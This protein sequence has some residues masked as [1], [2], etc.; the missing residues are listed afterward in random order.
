MAAETVVLIGIGCLRGYWRFAQ[1]VGAIMFA[2]WLALTIQ[3]KSGASISYLLFGLILVVGW[4]WSF[5]KS[6][7]ALGGHRP[8][9]HDR[10]ILD[11]VGGRTGLS[12]DG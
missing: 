4:L 8:G 11:A 12:L 7:T 6:A 2:L 10:G 3:D 9:S 5:R 1:T